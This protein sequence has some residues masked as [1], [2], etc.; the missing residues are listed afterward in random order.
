MIS[1]ARKHDIQFTGLMISAD[2]NIEE[3]IMIKFYDK[4]DNLEKIKIVLIMARYNNKWVFCKHGTTY[5]CPGG[6]VEINESYYNAACRELEEETGAKEY[7]MAFLSYFSLLG[8]EEFKE[9]EVFGA[10]YIADVYDFGKLS[11]EIKKIDFFN[12]IPNQLSYPSTQNALMDF[13]RR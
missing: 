2:K 12:E 9:V 1:V 13:I 6:H 5:E 11:Y 3:V 4:I 8:T 7:S 10:Y